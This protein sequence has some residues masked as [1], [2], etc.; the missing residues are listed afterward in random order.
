MYFFNDSSWK[1]VSLNFLL[2]NLLFFKWILN[3][4]KYNF[5]TY[6]QNNVITF[7]EKWEYP[8][9]LIAGRKDKKIKKYISFLIRK[10]QFYHHFNNIIF[11][12]SIMSSNKMSC[13]VE[14]TF[15]I[16][17]FLFLFCSIRFYL[18]NFFVKIKLNYWLII[19]INE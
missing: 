6:L 14:D 15:F 10:A 16:T 13:F 1:N 12:F 17:S 3:Y 19:F 11:P 7:N 18:F 4:C 2:Y 5:G 8:T 9:F